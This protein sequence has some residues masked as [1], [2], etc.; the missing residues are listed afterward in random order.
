MMKPPEEGWGSCPIDGR[1]WGTSQRTEKTVIDELT[2]KFEQ[3]RADS[4]KYFI[5]QLIVVRSTL[6]ES[7]T[8][9]FLRRILR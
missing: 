6:S 9:I 3:S 5:L 8:D 7:S 1:D 4:G 2:M